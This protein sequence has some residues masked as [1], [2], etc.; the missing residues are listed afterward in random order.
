VKAHIGF[1]SGRLW[2]WEHLEDLGVDG[3]VIVKCI[4]SKYNGGGES[5]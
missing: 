2:E 1:R 5:A 4:F 3:R